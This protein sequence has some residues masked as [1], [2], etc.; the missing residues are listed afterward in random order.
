VKPRARQVTMGVAVMGAVLV[1]ILTV[2][3]WRQVTIQYYVYRLR[4][5]PEYLKTALLFWENEVYQ[6]ALESYLRTE[7]GRQSL[8][9]LFLDEFL[10]TFDSCSQSFFPGGS[11]P[12]RMHILEAERIALWIGPKTHGFQP[13]GENVAIHIISDTGTNG[14][15][16]VPAEK[17]IGRLRAL[18]RALATILGERV[19]LEAYQGYCFRVMA[20]TELIQERGELDLSKHRPREE[21]VVCVAERS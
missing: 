3:C 14:V 8:V 5:D 20:G 13:A 2:A 19:E 18:N 10:N 15:F 7:K 21:D 4:L 16:V 11:K 1:V 12:G 9:K 6:R 17:G